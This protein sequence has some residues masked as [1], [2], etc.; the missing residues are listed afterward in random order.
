MIYLPVHAKT[1]NSR[2][3]FSESK[4]ELLKGAYCPVVLIRPGAKAQRKVILAAVN[5][6]A[7]RD[8]QIELNKKMEAQQNMIE[9]LEKNKKVTTNQ[10]L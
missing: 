6:Q 5:M 7:Q 9:G 2:F 4:W 10:S 3:S 1:N 8:V